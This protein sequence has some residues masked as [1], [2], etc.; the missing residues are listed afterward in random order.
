MLLLKGL[1]ELAD[2]LSGLLFW[3]IMPMLSVWQVFG[4]RRYAQWYDEEV[5]PLMDED[6]RSWELS[7]IAHIGL[8]HEIIRRARMVGWV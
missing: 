5:F 6:P 8:R 2:G 7:P 4:N 3:Y 1:M